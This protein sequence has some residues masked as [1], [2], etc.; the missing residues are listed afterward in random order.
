[1][2]VMMI[3]PSEIFIRVSENRNFSDVKVLVQET[4]IGK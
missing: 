2:T 4:E 1:M 3:A